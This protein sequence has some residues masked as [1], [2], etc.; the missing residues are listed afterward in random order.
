VLP[1]HLALTWKQV[2]VFCSSKPRLPLLLPG[3]LPPER[4]ALIS[5]AR[6]RVQLFDFAAAVAAAATLPLH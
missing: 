1:P 4:F 2:S 5:A 3:I 6:H